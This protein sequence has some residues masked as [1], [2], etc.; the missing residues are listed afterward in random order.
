[1]VTLRSV[2]RFCHSQSESTVTDV[3]LRPPTMKLIV[4]W[5]LS[6]PISTLLFVRA[7]RSQQTTTAV[8]TQTY[9]S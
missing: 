3:D 2:I 8:A 5:T 1:M 7:V 4:P 6:V 9:H